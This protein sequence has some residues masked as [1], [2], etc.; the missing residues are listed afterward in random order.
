MKKLLNS[1]K[2]LTKKH[3]KNLRNSVKSVGLA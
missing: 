1:Q 2:I 3:M